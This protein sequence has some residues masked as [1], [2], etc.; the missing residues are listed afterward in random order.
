MKYTLKQWRMLRGMSQEELA[1]A[2]GK[3]SY[4]TI[5]HW[6]KGNYEPRVSDIEALKKAL[7]LK[8]SDSIIVGKE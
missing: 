6:E 2:I 3:K 1:K 7:K 4:I 5:Y 8:A